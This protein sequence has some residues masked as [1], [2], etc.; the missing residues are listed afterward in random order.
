MEFSGSERR[1]SKFL[2]AIVVA[3][4]VLQP[5]VNLTLTGT[6]N[7]EVHMEAAVKIRRVA[8][9][10][11]S[12]ERSEQRDERSKTASK[13]RGEARGGVG[14]DR[15]SASYVAMIEWENSLGFRGTP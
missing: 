11:A 6:L 9:E 14:P 15:R 8:E 12:E 10:G 3:W 13:E 4:L 7:V 5:S 1:L 2:R